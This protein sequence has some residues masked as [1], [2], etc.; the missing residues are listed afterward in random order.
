MVSE[1]STRKPRTARGQAVA[2]TGD[3]RLALQLVVA[4]YVEAMSA[5]LQAMAK[6]AG[7]D[8]L[9]YFLG[10]ARLE[11]SITVERLSAGHERQTAE[12]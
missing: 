10:M 4:G 12:L 3:Q 9:A 6:A 7:L 11:G 2:G 5:E 8:S 1:K